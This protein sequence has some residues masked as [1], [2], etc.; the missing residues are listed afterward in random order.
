M[1]IALCD[2]DETELNAL[3]GQIERLRPEDTIFLFDD[4]L[5]VI[6]GASQ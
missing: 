6:K 3:R 1:Q 5:N 2:D 4:F